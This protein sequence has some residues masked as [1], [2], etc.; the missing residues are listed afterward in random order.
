MATAGASAHDEMGGAA[1]STAA[2]ARTGKEAWAT[3]GT[4]REKCRAPRAALKPAPRVAPIAT[5]HGIMA[6][7]TATNIAASAGK[8]QSVNA[9]PTSNS[10]S[11][12]TAYSTT[13]AQS[14]AAETAPE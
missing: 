7:G 12:A 2:G 5:H 4:T 11:P 14:V 1:A 3:A 10:T 9:A 13:K 6:G 8:V